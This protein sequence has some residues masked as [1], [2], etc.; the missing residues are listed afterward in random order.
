MVLLVSRFNIS[1][2]K[3]TIVQKYSRLSGKLCSLKHK[4]TSTYLHQY[5]YWPVLNTNNGDSQ[6]QNLTPNQNNLLHTCHI[7]DQSRPPE[8]R[9]TEH[10][11]IVNQF[12]FV[13]I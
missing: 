9:E 10:C 2:Y 6:W 1:S 8:K 5:T 4:R 11:H 13:I 3:R 7:S 12:H